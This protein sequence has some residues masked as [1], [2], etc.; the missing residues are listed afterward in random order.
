MSLLCAFVFVHRSFREREKKRQRERKS[1]VFT[2]E[3]LRPG[4][5]YYAGQRYRK[6]QRQKK[7][8]K[9][10]ETEKE[11]EIERERVLSN[12]HSLPLSPFLLLLFLLLFQPYSV[13]LIGDKL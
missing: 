6:R 4:R 5:G 8:N 11:R 12:Q 13:I 2:H 3:A 9:G 10:R 7:R 1:P